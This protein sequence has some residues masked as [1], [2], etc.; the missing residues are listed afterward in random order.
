MARVYILFWD[1]QNGFQLCPCSNRNLSQFQIDIHSLD[2]FRAHAYTPLY[3]CAIF[4]T[5]VTLTLEG[6]VFFIEPSSL[7]S[8]V[9]TVPFILL[10][11]IM[12][13]HVMLLCVIKENCNEVEEHFMVNNYLFLY[14]F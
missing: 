1:A 10:A 3:Q 9:Y 12:A 7:N 5:F 11:L 14:Q 4:F 2:L 8:L 6:T 13:L